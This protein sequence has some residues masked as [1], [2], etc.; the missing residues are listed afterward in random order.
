MNEHDLMQ[1]LERRVAD[2]SPTGAPVSDMVG[3][4]DKHRKR[5][6]VLTAVAGAAAVAVVATSLS[7]VGFGDDNASAPD[8]VS[9]GGVS[10]SLG[11]ALAVIPSDSEV[12][13]FT[14]RERAATRLGLK[15]STRAEYAEA[16]AEYVSSTSGTGAE[17][18][19]GLF[20]PMSS[21]L[22]PTADP[23][24]SDFDV[25]WSAQGGA[26]AVGGYTVYKMVSGAD[27]DAV[28][29]D[30]AAAG[31]DE[32]Q[33][34]GRRHLVTDNPA[35][36]SS[37]SGIIGNGYPRDFTDVTIDTEANL[38]IV[39]EASERVLEVL[40]GERESMAEAGTFDTLLSDTAL[41]ERATLTAAPCG[42]AAGDSEPTASGYLVYGSDV[43]LSARMSFVD[44]DSAAADL[45]ARLPF[46]LDAEFGE[47]GRQLSTF[48][49]F[50]INQRGP[51]IDIEATNMSSEV[52]PD[53][54]REPGS[55]IGC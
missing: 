14:D 37:P 13:F 28:G 42:K 10:G 49:S 21:S 47:E 25:V 44:D 53:L 9:P 32:E 2:V 31:L 19:G 26:D 4:A 55:I 36:V 8:V 29:D 3:R 50:D 15:A 39:G 46:L 40:D 16:I 54:T 7:L 20:S 52:L 38:L 34:L 22:V 45:E 11:D 33:L 1:A 17:D 51:L 6:N 18:P 43:R 12:L 27:L 5:R 48:G 23:P 24:L 35:S 41:V 30:L